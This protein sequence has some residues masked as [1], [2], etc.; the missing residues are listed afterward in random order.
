M[1]QYCNRLSF[2]LSPL[3]NSFDLYS[4]KDYH[5]QID[6]KNL[7]PDL[8]SLLDTLGLKITFVPIF[9]TRPYQITPIHSD[10]A[11]QDP[12]FVKL[13][14]VYDEEDSI[15]VWYKPK[16]LKTISALTASTA[17]PFIQYSA[18]E[19]EEV[20]RQSLNGCSLVLVKCPHNVLVFSK[21]RYSISLTLRKK[22][23]N[24]V[25]TMDEAVLI[26]KDYLVPLVR[27]EPTTSRF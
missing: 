16:I 24:S 3:I 6:I 5:T 19:V 14:F 23:S 26:F 21:P 1:N 27:F 17:K 15:M 22:E 12:N 10:G 20:H 18:D 7:N 2:N 25:L 9:Y 4:I 13:N 8:I 11:Y